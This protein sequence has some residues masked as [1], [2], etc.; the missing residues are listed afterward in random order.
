MKTKDAHHMSKNRVSLTWSFFIEEFWQWLY[1]L[2]VDLANHCTWA[3]E[4]H[5]CVSVCVWAPSPVWLPL[6]GERTNL[7]STGFP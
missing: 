7:S 4:V 6:S 5:A 3:D 2:I 1:E